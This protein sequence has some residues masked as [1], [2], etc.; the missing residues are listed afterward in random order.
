MA[1]DVVA[2]S[3]IAN[4]PGRR[5]RFK[6]PFEPAATSPSARALGEAPGDVSEIVPTADSSTARDPARSSTTA[7][8][9]AG[10]KRAEIKTAPAAFDPRPKGNRALDA[11]TFLER[12]GRNLCARAVTAAT[13][14]GRE[15]ATAAF[16][17]PPEET[18][19]PRRSRSARTRP[20]A[21]ST[22]VASSPPR[23]AAPTPPPLPAA[24][25]SG[26]S[27][28]G[29]RCGSAWPDGPPPGP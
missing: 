21:R 24:P 14:G 27:M 13:K 25:V 19:A 2:V 3:P 9:K 20:G 22:R 11:R 17:P 23:P 26:T 1:L 8:R 29:C 16:D 18:R 10:N 12:D 7:R 4:H 6:P 15:A 5:R 28:P